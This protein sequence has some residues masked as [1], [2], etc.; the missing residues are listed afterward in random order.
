ML[1]YPAGTIYAAHRD[2]V[3]KFFRNCFGFSV[4]I[5]ASL[6]VGVHIVTHYLSI[7][8]GEILYNLKGIAFALLIVCLMTRVELRSVPLSWMG[9]NL[10]EIYIYQRLPMVALV[11]L[12]PSTVSAHP[13]GFVF[14]SVLV[15]VG[16][17][18]LI[19]MAK[20]IW[21]SKVSPVAM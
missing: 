17:V 4:A 20:G 9:E 21:R 18:F 15:T 12:I 7:S 13:N 19:Q 2:Y 14:V 8:H 6:A 1:A 16:I 11:V 5:L 10:F 3:N